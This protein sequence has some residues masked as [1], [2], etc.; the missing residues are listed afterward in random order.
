MLSN[1]DKQNELS[2]DPRFEQFRKFYSDAA[3]S[4]EASLF[5]FF[6][7]NNDIFRAIS[8]EDEAKIERSREAYIRKTVNWTLG[9]LAGVFFLDQIVLRKTN[10][11]MNRL[12]TPMFLAKYLGV[13]AASFGVAKYFL[14]QDFHQTV[15]EVSDKYHFEFDDYLKAMTLLESAYKA[16][17]LDELYEVGQKFDWNT[18]KK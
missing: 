9:G 8:P 1:Y 7:E 2:R 16:G 10:L 6:Y 4:R 14:C 3:G 12:K 5:K 18:I 13:P 11:K 17:K 15:R